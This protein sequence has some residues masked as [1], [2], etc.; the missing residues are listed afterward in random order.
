MATR[1][2]IELTGDIWRIVELEGRRSWRP[3]RP[4]TVVRSYIDVPADDGQARVARV[5]GRAASVVV[6]GVPSRHRQVIVNHGT[7]EAM[8]DEARATLDVAGIDMSGTWSDI[9]PAGPHRGEKRRPVVV[10]IA[11]AAAMRSAIQPLVCAGLRVRAVMTPAAAL[12]AMARSRR[13]ASVADAIEVYVALEETETCLALLRGGTLVAARDIAW[14]YRG[15]RDARPENA[16]REAV[17]LRLGDELAEF[18]DALGEPMS[19]VQQI[20]VCGGAPD[21]RSTVVPLMERFDVEVEPLDSLYAIDAAR[22]PHAGEPFSDRVAGWRIAWAAAAEW[23]PAMNLL[24]P[25]RRQ[26][27][28][29]WLGRVAVLA[30]VAAGVGAGVGVAASAPPPRR[31]ANVESPRHRSQI[32]ESSRR[33]RQAPEPRAVPAIRQEPPLLIR[34]ELPVI[35][36]EPDAPAEETIVN[37]PAMLSRVLKRAPSPPPV[38]LAAS[39]RAA[40]A[41]AVVETIL[42]SADRQLAIVDGRIVARGD[43]VRGSMVVEVTPHAVVMRDT[44]GRIVRLSGR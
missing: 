33:R 9:A 40:A 26:Q 6:W 13:A 15:A 43:I 44:E 2:G 41:D 23:P 3:G 30:G 20:C 29:A 31:T 1:L 8:R 14:G 4:D 17:A 7:Y 21:L 32:A 24:R 22:L 35:R 16:R 34:H 37:H 12:A 27:S 25:I 28:H 42:F 19:A 5:R 18:F 10:T 11:S 36:R 39:R 38:R